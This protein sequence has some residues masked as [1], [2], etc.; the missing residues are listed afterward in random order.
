MEAEAVPS[1]KFKNEKLQNALKPL[2]S[3][4]KRLKDYVAAIML[5]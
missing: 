4:F 2:K 5:G 3:N 1:Q